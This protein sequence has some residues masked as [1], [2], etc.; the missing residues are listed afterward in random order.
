MLSPRNDMIQCDNRAE[1]GQVPV[2]DLDRGSDLGL[3]ARSFFLNAQ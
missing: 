2:M 1:G 3:F